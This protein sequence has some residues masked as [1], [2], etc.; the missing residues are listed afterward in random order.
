MDPSKYSFAGHMKLLD[1][2]ATLWLAQNYTFKGHMVIIDLMGVTFSHI[3]K[4]GLL[5][6]KKILTYL[7]DAMPVRLKGMHFVNIVPFMDK[8]LALMKP[9]MKKELFDV[10]HLHTDDFSTLYPYVPKRCLPKNYGGEAPSFEELHSKD[11]K[12]TYK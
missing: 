6:M 3:T 9:F 4:I 7:Q 10:L 2:T 8:L 1:M 5:Q 11:E 12:S